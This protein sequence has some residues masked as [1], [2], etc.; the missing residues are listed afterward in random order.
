MSITEAPR[1]HDRDA[2]R[3]NG[4]LGDS[5]TRPDGT[6]KVQGSFAFSSDLHA[7]NCLWG[8]TLR[9][10]HP[11]ARIVAIDTT[12]AW[13]IAGVEAIVTADDVPGKMTYGLISQDQPVFARDVLHVGAEGFGLL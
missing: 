3:S 8:A 11:H 1:R 10:P 9:S 5:I 6:A 4:R 13:K 12:P 7:E 2:G